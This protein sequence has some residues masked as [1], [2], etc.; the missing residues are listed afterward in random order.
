MS[1]ILSDT[2][3]NPVHLTVINNGKFFPD[4]V[5]FN[6]M[7]KLSKN[8][9]KHQA[10]MFVSKRTWD[11]L[12]NPKVTYKNAFGEDFEVLSKSEVNERFVD[13]QLDLANS[14]WVVVW[15]FPEVLNY[16]I[17][18]EE[19]RVLK[20]LYDIPLSAGQGKLSNDKWGKLQTHEHLHL[21]ASH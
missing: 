8:Q 11:Y 13:G 15:R 20:R 14:D 21:S 3:N 12:K 5:Y 2:Q 19:K 16:L 7:C 9:H 4:P 18:T 10:T 1:I 17:D 6:P